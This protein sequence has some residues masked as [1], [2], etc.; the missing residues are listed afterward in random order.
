MAEVMHRSENLVIRQLDD[1]SIDVEIRFASSSAKGTAEGRCPRCGG[2]GRP[3]HW[4][5]EGPDTRG[6]TLWMAC[7]AEVAAC[8][9]DTAGELT[10]SVPV[11][12]S[13]GWDERG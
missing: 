12:F 1:L 13:G 8:E 3:T 11:D 5:L 9:K 10:W 6:N 7:G 2:A 4:E